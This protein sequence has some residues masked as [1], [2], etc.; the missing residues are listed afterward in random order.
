MTGQRRAAVPDIGHPG[1]DGSLNATPSSDGKRISIALP[2]GAG[3]PSRVCTH[4]PTHKVPPLIWEIGLGTLFVA[5]P[6]EHRRYGLSQNPYSAPEDLARACFAS[7]GRPY[8][9]PNTVFF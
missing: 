6:P 5:A 8:A 1:S 3:V 9:R 4:S 2:G 7:L